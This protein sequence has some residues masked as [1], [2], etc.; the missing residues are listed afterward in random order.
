MLAIIVPSAN[1]A[2]RTF[3]NGALN[4]CA[5][6]LLSTVWTALGSDVLS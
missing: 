6:E 2:E 5:F 4:A 1:F 3:L